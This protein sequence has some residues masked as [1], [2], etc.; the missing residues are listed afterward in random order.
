MFS[1]YGM[2]KI[3]MVGL[4]EKH[5][6]DPLGGAKGGAKRGSQKGELKGGDP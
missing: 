2:L 4:C 6:G 3:V 1:D 5:L